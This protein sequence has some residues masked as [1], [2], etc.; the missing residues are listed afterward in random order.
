MNRENRR[1]P[2]SLSEKNRIVGWISWPS[3]GVLLVAGLLACAMGGVETEDGGPVANGPLSTPLT[4]ATPENPQ[5]DTVI[6]DCA[7][8]PS[9]RLAVTSEQLNQYFSTSGHWRRESKVEVED[10]TIFIWTSSS[11]QAMLVWQDDDGVVFVDLIVNVPYAFNSWPSPTPD[12]ELRQVL[13][14]ALP[15]WE[16]DHASEVRTIWQTYEIN[17]AYRD[18]RPISRIGDTIMEIYYLEGIPAAAVRVLPNE[19]MQRP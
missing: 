3:M 2:A 4:A 17:P 13:S 8:N 9:C 14:E 6:D 11:E 7:V 18:V 12:G 1:E 15:V 5:R 16:R 19:V 10:G